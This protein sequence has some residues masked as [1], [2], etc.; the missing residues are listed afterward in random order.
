MARRY[1]AAIASAQHRQASWLELF[2]DAFDEGV[3]PLVWALAMV[4]LM[5]FPVLAAASQEARFRFRSEVSRPCLT[6]SAGVAARRRDS[7]AR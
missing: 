2:F 1:R 5:A 4:V 7:D 3:R 6:R